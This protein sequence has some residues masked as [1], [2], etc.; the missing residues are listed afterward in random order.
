MMTDRPYRKA[1][2]LFEVTTE[3]KSNAGSQ[4]DPHVITAFVDL[5]A[6]DGQRILSITDYQSLASL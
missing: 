2:S 1:L 3:L 5:L 6:T 4:F